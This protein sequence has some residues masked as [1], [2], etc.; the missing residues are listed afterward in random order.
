[1]ATGNV[2]LYTVISSPA[3]SGSAEFLRVLYYMA[4]SLCD[5]ATPL[6]SSL[7]Q[8]SIGTKAS[9]NLFYLWS[10][11]SLR[12]GVTLTGRDCFR[13]QSSIGTKTLVILWVSGWF[14][15]FAMGSPFWVE[16][17]LWAYALD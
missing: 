16:F 9:L 10:N 3:S 5:E 7:Y 12:D 8:Y 1:M 4:Q 17:A 2:N 11:A 15:A 14:R 6:G 13:S